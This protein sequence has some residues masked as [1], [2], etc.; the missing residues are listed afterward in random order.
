[1]ASAP[2]RMQPP[3]ESG[4]LED[5]LWA[6]AQATV[7][8]HG[9]EFA[10]TCENITEEFVRNGAAQLKQ[11]GKADA[12]EAVSQAVHNTVRYVELMIGDAA[13]GTTPTELHENNFR[14]AKSRFCPCFPFC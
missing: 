11:A 8:A 6:V 7:T 5:A 13:S 2:F 1:M 10:T 9:V 14:Q 12:P 4:S 3:D